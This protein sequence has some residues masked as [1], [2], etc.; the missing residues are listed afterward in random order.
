M[1]SYL[2]LYILP[3]LFASLTSFILASF[4]FLR[5]KTSP[6]N[7]S[8]F[9]LGMLTSFWKFTHFIF[10]P[11]KEPAHFFFWAKLSYVF[12][13]FIP[14]AT[15][16]F[17]VSFL[18]LK[19]R[20]L[21][22]FYSFS[23][24]FLLFLGHKNFIVGMKRYPWG[25]YPLVGLTHNIILGFWVIPIVYS[26]LALYK[27]YKKETNPYIRKRIKYLLVT[28]SIAY[29]GAIDY[30]P[31]YGI[32]LYPLGS[33]FL[34]LFICLATYA[35]LRWR[36]LDIGVIIKKITLISTIF[37]SFMALVYFLSLYL[38]PYL[39]SLWG[40]NWIIL[41]IF[42]SFLA[43]LFLSF[44]IRYLY[45]IKEEELSQK[46]SYSSLLKKE[47]QRASD[48][49]NLNEL[50]AYLIRDVTNWAKLDYAGV[51]L[52]D[53]QTK[54]YNL[55]R[56][57]RR[58]PNKKR[59]A[60]GLK[61]PP[62]NPLIVELLKKRR[63]LIYSELLHLITTQNLSP[64]EREFLFKLT[65][66]MK[67]L[68]AEI[69][70]P[71]FCEDKLQA[72]INLGNKLNPKEIITPEEIELFFS[73]SNH[74]ARA[75]AGFLLKEEK[76]QLIITSQNILISAIEAKDHYTRS[77]TERVSFYST[78]LGKKLEKYLRAYPNG[79]SNLNWAA[80]LHDVGKIGISD[81]I[82]LKPGQLSSE[83]WYNIKEHPL[84]GLRIIG[85]LHDWL[86]EDICQAILHH[87][88][89]YDGSGYPSHQKGESIHLFARIIRVA[90]AF[91]A[92]TTSRPYRPALSKKEA[93]EELIRYK[94]IYF[95]P[96]V[97]E[98]MVELYEEGKI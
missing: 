17:V 73:L 60:T 21:L 62:D 4:I 66:E 64:L 36:L 34:L 23:F 26:F 38:Q 27:G 29:L 61:I 96:L 74:I 70:I 47:A 3:P 39:F 35:I 19:R 94:E 20:K 95:D 49:K 10:Y 79:L 46:L 22:F 76:L 48:S 98:A 56:S 58:S 15:Y 81:K 82:L 50:L 88:E 77:H 32:N 11:L 87:H 90:D 8:F 30:L 75:L 80:Q 9:I 68:E 89:N 33:F 12:I 7:Q 83:E 2:N 43:S 31:C 25:N 85:S 71:C 84:N 55:V 72:I 57:L 28:L 6:V 63:P 59:L 44:F 14:S 1:S 91:D 18:N 97:V 54:S 40:R 78:L 41:P 67:R 53:I 92:M 42:F 65:N 51:L 86:G 69:S 52:W 37:I 93:I 5:N 45:R 16:H 24:L 13:F